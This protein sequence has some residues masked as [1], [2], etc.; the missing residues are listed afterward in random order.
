MGSRLDWSDIQVF[1][2]IA[3]A[4]TLSGAAEVSGLSQPTIGRRLRSFESALG[5][6]LFHR[7]G[8]Y[9]ELTPAGK[10]LQAIGEQ[11]EHAAISAERTLVG[12]DA[13]LAG[14]LIVTSAEWLSVRLLTRAVADFSR[15][16][17]A[18][19]VDLLADPNRVNLLRDDVDVALRLARFS[20]ADV[21]QRCIGTV[22]FGL[23]ASREYLDRLGPPNFEQH[24]EGHTLIALTH[25]RGQVADVAWL[26]EIA[27]RARIAVRCNGREAQARF[28]E[29][30]A[31][32]ACLPRL[33]GD[34]TAGLVLL[35]SPVPP[36]RKLWLGVHGAVKD[37][38]R[39]RTF[40]EFIATGLSPQVY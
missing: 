28:A 22:S 6:R 31:G 25:A 29:A 15:M 34:A 21:N 40:S 26:E 7:R 9:L 36:S 10:S 4:G 14:Q 27:S 35:D 16:H 38:K 8:L 13:D 39:V 1:V 2:A 17:P 23:Y 32:L 20:E 37:I 30:G 11:M 12:R 19:L 33:V 5:T 18:I 3:R 24:C